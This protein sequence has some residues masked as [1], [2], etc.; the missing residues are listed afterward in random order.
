MFKKMT[1]IVA[2]YVGI[3]TVALSSQPSNMV[4]DMANSDAEN[5]S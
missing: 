4:T 5:N 2:L 3:I 1:V